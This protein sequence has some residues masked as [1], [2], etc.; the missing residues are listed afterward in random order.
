MDVLNFNSIIHHCTQKTA[1]NGDCQ[2]ISQNI[3]IY[4]VFN[5]I[6]IQVIYFTSTLGRFNFYQNHFIYY[7]NILIFIYYIYIT[8]NNF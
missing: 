3:L 8:V 2:Y 7:K 6:A 4:D 1:L 5:V